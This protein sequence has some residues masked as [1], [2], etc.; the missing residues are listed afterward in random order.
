MKRIVITLCVLCITVNGYTQL[1]ISSEIRPRAEFRHGYAK[2]PSDDA[3]P[4]AI[5]SQRT[6]LNLL[7]SGDKFT[8]G[9]AVQDTRVWGDETL[10]SATGVFGDDA[11]IDMKEGWIELKAGKNN[12]FKTG[13]QYLV[14]LDERILSARNW[15]QNSIT[16]D[17][18]LYKFHKNRF[19]LHVCLSYNNNKEHI[20]GNDYNFYREVARFDTV[21][22]TL[23]TEQIVQRP[24]IRTMNFLYLSKNTGKSELSFIGIATGFQNPETTSVNYI[25][26]TYGGFYKYTGT[27]LNL[28]STVYY[29]NGRNVSGSEVSAYMFHILGDYNLNRFNLSAGIDYISGQDQLNKSESYQ[30]K[31]HFFDIFYGNRHG[32]YGHMDYFSNMSVATQYGGL[33]DTYGGLG[34]RASPG[35]SFKV[36]YHHFRLQNRVAD[37]ADASV[38]LDKNLASEFDLSVKIK[39]L[40]E[41]TLDGGFSFLIP[42]ENLET[43]QGIAPGTGKF[44]YWGWLMLTAKPV[45]FKG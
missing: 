32:Y 10:S 9:L 35:T 6:R 39:L 22:N 42:A 19:D 28:R 21:S 20:F 29:Q 16:Y 43:M 5:V 31:D 18:F 26:G 12:T 38:A 36:V 24:R 4:A 40:P 1:R 3:I 45:L 25:R 7:Y 17:A 13:R 15:N 8:F 2:L 11:S 33:V 41:I 14:Y 44:A 27:N 23:V 34:F 30:G 37:P